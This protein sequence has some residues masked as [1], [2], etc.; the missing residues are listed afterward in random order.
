MPQAFSQVSTALLRRWRWSVGMYCQDQ[1]VALHN[2]RTIYAVLTVTEH[3]LSTEPACPRA[4]IQLLTRCRHWSRS[5][6]SQCK[7]YMSWRVSGGCDDC[8]LRGPVVGGISATELD[9]K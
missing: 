7:S 9:V 6:H 4:A 5:R 1:S 8:G 3:Q 2:C